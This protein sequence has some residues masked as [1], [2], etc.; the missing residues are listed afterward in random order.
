MSTRV[1]N[2]ASAG[3]VAK[4]LRGSMATLRDEKFASAD[5]NFIIEQNCETLVDL[6]KLTSRPTAKLVADGARLA[7]NCE[8]SSG[9]LFG[10]R[11]AA[12]VSHCRTK[13]N[14]MTTGRKLPASL[15]K[16]ISALGSIS[17]SPSP[18]NSPAA[19]YDRL[20]GSGKKLLRRVSSASSDCEVAE[21][22]TKVAK[23]AMPS[24]AAV[25]SL[26]GAHIS[27]TSLEPS[28]VV[29]IS[30]SE[31]EATSAAGASGAAGAD[32]ATKL[33]VREYLDRGKPCMMRCYNDGSFEESNMTPGPNG[34]CM[35][36]F[37]AEAPTETEV[38]NLIL[39]GKPGVMK[40]PAAAKGVMKKPAAA[41]QDVADAGKTSAADEV[42][43]QAEFVLVCGVVVVSWLVS[44]V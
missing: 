6:L 4:V 16:V 10:E 44:L 13:K 23:L 1:K 30:D 27:S 14:Q 40:K 8:L 15:L 26:Y 2:S 29:A 9:K 7:F 32:K 31:G 22:T 36:Q 17:Q 21:P 19:K 12:A 5:M 20:W 37:G 43:D 18:S 28:G 11:M 3:D 35:S 33:V 42:F 38:P 41:N 39:M 34:F 24:Q 25:L